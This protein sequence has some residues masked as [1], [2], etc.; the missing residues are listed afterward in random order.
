MA[1]SRQPGS[2]DSDHGIVDQN[3]EHLMRVQT[4]A[5]ST[6]TIPQEVRE[7][8]AAQGIDGYLPMVVDLATRA[9]PSSALILSVDED[10]ED[11]RHRYVALDVQAGALDADRLLAG[12][13]VW[14]EGVL[15]VCPSRYAS[16]FVLGWQ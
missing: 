8:A 3:V 16:Y 10:A 12:Q 7:F 4:A 6:L 9:F 2:V 15:R 13:R 1:V 11:Q 5:L 14:S